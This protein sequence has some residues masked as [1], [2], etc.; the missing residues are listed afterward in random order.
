MSSSRWFPT[1]SRFPER[2]DRAPDEGYDVMLSNDS[3]LAAHMADHVLMAEQE[4][5]HVLDPSH[6][7]QTIFGKILSDLQFFGWRESIRL[8]LS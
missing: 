1:F 6:R 7:W 5:L 4:Q 2:M 8:H 3:W